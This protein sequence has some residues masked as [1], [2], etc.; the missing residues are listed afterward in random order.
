MSD[1]NEACCRQYEKNECTRGGFCNFM[2]LK[3]AGKRIKHEL[4]TYVLLGRPSRLCDLTGCVLTL[5]RTTQGLSPVCWP[6]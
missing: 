3:V 1:F 2:H 5:A 6:S 4:Y